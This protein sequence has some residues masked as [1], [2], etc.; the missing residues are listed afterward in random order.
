MLSAR[1]TIP[2]LLATSLAA[3]AAHAADYSPPQCY[4][5]AFIASGRAPYG[6]VP[7]YVPPPVVEEFS[8]WYLR[9]D[10]GF[11]NQ[12]VGSIWNRNYANY[13]SDVNID[14]SFDAAPLF[15]IGIGYNFN[16]WLRFDLTGEYRGKAN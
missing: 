6:A 11:S 5:A 8:S 13:D 3:G 10:I 4:D 7:C 15:G 12:S 14:R 1:L 2:I 16:D 9:G